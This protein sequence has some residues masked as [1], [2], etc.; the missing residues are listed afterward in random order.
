MHT[1]TILNA[2]AA[3]ALLTAITLTAITPIE[4]DTVV[5]GSV[6]IPSMQF[7]NANDAPFYVDFTLTGTNT[8]SVD[9]T[10]F[11]FG[12]GNAI[13][14]TGIPTN[15]VSG[16]IPGGLILTAGADFYNDYF[17]QFNP[18]S[19]LTFSLS[20]DLEG[21]Q[22]Q[23]PDTL[24][25]S[26]LDF[27]DDQIPTLDP[28][29]ADTV[30]TLNLLTTP[31]FS[32]YANDAS[33]SNDDTTYP[34]F[35]A[36]TFSQAQASAP[37][38]PTAIYLALG[39]GMCLLLSRRQH[40]A[41]QMTTAAAIA[42]IS[43]GTASAQTCKPIAQSAT[44]PIAVSAG[45]PSTAV[46]VADFDGDGIPDMAIASG[47][48][49][50]ELAVF[51]GNGSGGFSPFGGSPFALSSTLMNGGA[52]TSMMAADFNH[53]GKMDLILIS[54]QGSL[55][56][57]TG[58]GNGVFNI[59]TSANLALA[60]DGQDRNLQV[61][62]LNGDGYPDV[63]VAGAPSSLIVLNSAGLLAATQ[64]FTENAA[65]LA[66]VNGDGFPDVVGVSG[67]IYLNNTHGLMAVSASSLTMPA[68][69]LPAGIVAGDFNGD[70]KL[71]LLFVAANPA[72]TSMEYEF[73]IGNGSGS[74][75]SGTL[76]PTNISFT[77]AL[78]SANLVS[79]DFNG[80]G[81][82][83]FAFVQRGAVA[84]S[85]YIYVYEGTGAGAFALAFGSPYQIGE[86]GFSAQLVAVDIN[87][88]GRA[89]LIAPSQ[90]ASGN[91]NAYV[92]VTS[93]ATTS[94]GLTTSANPA[95]T[96]SPLTLT[97]V[98]G[99]ISA[100]AAPTGHVEFA[101]DGGT[102]NFVSLANG[103]ASFTIP[104][105][106][107]AGVHT[108]TAAY[109]GDGF[110]HPS[111]VQYA[112]FV[113]SSACS[114]NIT[115]QVAFRSGGFVYDRAH[116][117]FVQTVSITNFGSQALTGP[118]TLALDS[119]SANATLVSPG[120][121]TSCATP[122]HTPLADMGICPASPL[123]AGGS[124]TVTLRFNDPTLAAIS[125]TPRVLAGLAPR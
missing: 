25:M 40:T 94:M 44:S 115:A 48:S 99:G 75:A 76:V 80:D 1:K 107:T 106:L 54:N 64:G 49:N 88:D 83:D 17:Q 41:R 123:P 104:A 120:G 60:P 45:L 112:E 53:D 63:L 4:A 21:A 66:D 124:A 2:A 56:I 81:L 8:D 90:D 33:Q 98:I 18:A 6:S 37:E 103:Q 97:A 30:F 78:P 3:L 86:N 20:Y 32:G 102:G 85:A 95:I 92:Y 105:G 52:T 117:Q 79:G 100:C 122:A 12:R 35:A 9:L 74:F 61:A 110:Y 108:L 22:G 42:V 59:P 5:T 125:Y 13:P 116:Q 7:T 93:A 72:G 69:S 114:A 62:D 15:D 91:G 121:Y 73:F 14:G 101:V 70:G 111:T 27:S 36:A 19:I 87:A 24:T 65:W 23:T 109:S 113:G 82:P 68:S 10:N 16:S 77:S 43:L 31:Q 84:G 89:D 67:K 47:V 119:L 38:G 71:D 34:I 58:D 26:F 28:T 39:I 29:G 46:A 57:I 51:K 55:I 11:N 118:V 96:G 50:A